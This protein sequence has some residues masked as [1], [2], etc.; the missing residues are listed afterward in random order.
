MT[1]NAQPYRPIPAGLLPDTPSARY[2]TIRP[3]SLLIVS[4]HGETSVFA[5]ESSAVVLA[6]LRAAARAGESV[7]W[8]EHD[9][10]SADAASVSALNCYLRTA[11]TMGR[12]KLPFDRLPAPGTGADRFT[13]SAFCA[14]L[15]LIFA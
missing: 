10:R 9:G 13:W 5:A 15:G 7:V 6:R 1:R 2:L 14:H 4:K 8:F 3:V 12:M 11:R